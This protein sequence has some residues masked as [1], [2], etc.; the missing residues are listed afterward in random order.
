[1]Q[2]KPFKALFPKIN[3]ID[4]P[5]AFCD[6]AKNSFKKYLEADLFD[7]C[8]HE[9]F[10]VYE[11]EKGLHRHIGL[12]GLNK[13]EDFLEGRVKKHEDTLS[14][15]EWQQKELFL[16]WKAVLKPILVAHVP[17]PEINAWLHTFSHSHIPLM[18]V[19]FAKEETTHRFWSVTQPQDIIYLQSLYAQFVT[20]TYIADG[21]HRTTTTAMLHL[22][23]EFKSAG[24]D[25]SHL[26]CAWFAADQLDILDYNRVVQGVKKIGAAKVMAQLAQIC[27]IEI[28]EKPRKPLKKHEMVMFLDK[29]WYALRWRD[30]V[31]QQAPKG[32]ETLDTALLNDLVI[33]KI[34]DIVD[35]RT[36]TRITYVDGSKGL[37]GLK[38]ATRQLRN[39]RVGFVFYPVAFEDLAH[40][41]DAGEYLPPKSTYFE[42]RL[43][44]GLLV[45]L[46]ER[47]V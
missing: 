27:D 23:P 32:Y 26:F 35:V 7:R 43:K 5:A 37:E 16:R 14:E 4:S 20:E 22:D 46:L 8:V 6:D 12:V 30:F 15:R 47:S 24:L 3:Q 10:Y 19:R 13:V 31:L 11:I 42:P 40:M 44:S 25:L 45:R 38:K 9:G 28:L 17:V 41:A 18:T 39:D 29:E 36:D 2:I 34:F 33:N 21:H 1:M